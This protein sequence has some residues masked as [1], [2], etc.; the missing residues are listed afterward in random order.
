MS[1]P[2][3]KFQSL[4]REL[5]QFDCADLDFG[6]YRVMNQKRAMIEAFIEKD[7]IESVSK[8]LKK[9]ALKE[10]GELVGQMEALAEKIRE[11]IADD[12]IDADGSILNFKRKQLGRSQLPIWKR[13][14]STIYGISSA[15]TTTTAIS[16]PPVAIRAVRSM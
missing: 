7:L 4:L 6:I 3:E 10:Q 5:F 8:E 12:A 13:R 16:S 11:D 2:L 15:A 1:T 14:Y 9:S